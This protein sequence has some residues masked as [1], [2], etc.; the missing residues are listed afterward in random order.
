VA[1]SERPGLIDV[2]AHFVPDDYLAAAKAAGHE[3][4]DDFVWPAPWSAEEHLAVMDRLGI[5]LS[6]LSI[7]S[8]GVHFGDDAAARALARSVN[9][10]AAELVQAHPDRFRDFG[11]LPLPDVEGA[12]SEVAHV[13]D[14]LGAAGVAVESNAHGE[15]LGNPRN[16]PLWEELDRRGAIVFIHPT[17]AP[18]CEYVSLGRPRPMIEFIF[19]TVRTITDLL[20]AGVFERHPRIRFIVTHCGGAAALPMLAPRIESFRRMAGDQGAPTPALLAGLWYDLAGSPLPHQLGAL[21]GA[22][23]TERLLYGSDYAFTPEQTV[24]GQIASIEAA[25]GPDESVSWSAL[26]TS[27]AERLLAL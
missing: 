7:S 10:T 12:L 19:D 6:V 11:S 27:N 23:G 22:V 3:H 18:H 24:S 8:P 9:E 14:T 20:F 2:H 1:V 17:S 4:P 13:L 21:A 5:R 16:E 25:G 26:T 15:Y